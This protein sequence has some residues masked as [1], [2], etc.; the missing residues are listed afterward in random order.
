MHVI[1]KGKHSAFQDLDAGNGSMEEPAVQSS[2]PGAADFFLE[3][4]VSCQAAWQ[5]GPF[6]ET[7]VPSVPGYCGSSFRGCITRFT[8]SEKPRC[9]LP[10]AAC[11]L[12]ATHPPPLR[13]PD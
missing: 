8:W 7:L 12:H 13:C 4:N 10:Y 9:L 1:C 5:V 11:D 2:N 3:T 6:R